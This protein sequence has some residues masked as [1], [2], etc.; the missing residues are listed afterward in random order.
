MCFWGSCGQKIS[1]SVCHTD[2][3]QQSTCTIQQLL[4]ESSIGALIEHLPHSTERG[5]LHKV[6]T[7]CSLQHAVLVSLS[8]GAE[9]S[10]QAHP[11]KI[12]K[13]EQSLQFYPVGRIDVQTTVQTVSW[14]FPQCRLLR[15]DVRWG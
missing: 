9:P 14:K 2:I 7:V 8:P 5:L 6:R 1:F 13:S 10:L 3:N 12:T 15:K 11:C 4:C